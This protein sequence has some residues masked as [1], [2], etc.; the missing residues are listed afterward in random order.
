MCCLGTLFISTCVCAMNALSTV[1]GSLM[2][3]PTLCCKVKGLVNLVT[4]LQ[5]STQLLKS[6][7]FNLTFRVNCLVRVVRPDSCTLHRW[8]L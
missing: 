8:T 7:F 1:V 4:D 6:D 5:F 3:R 2:L